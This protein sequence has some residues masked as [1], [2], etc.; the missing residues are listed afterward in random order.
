MP[1]RDPR[2][3]IG[4]VATAVLVALAVYIVFQRRLT[5]VERERRRRVFVNR[6]RRTI[7]GV[8]TEAGEDLI[9]YQYE[10]RGVI[11]SASQDVSALHPLLPLFPD[12][13]IGPVSVKYDPRNPANSIVICEDW[14]GLTVKRESQD[15]IVE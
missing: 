3:F 15:A 7:E 14:S 1:I 12:R 13:L 2:Y 10:L 11:Y 5:P 6:S 8:I 9:Y 4:L